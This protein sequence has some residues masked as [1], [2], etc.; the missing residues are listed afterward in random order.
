MNE[1][2]GIEL[3][4]ITKNFNEKLETIKN[5][6]VDF[7]KIA[8]QNF[9]T[10]LYMDV[11]KAKNDLEKLEKTL[12][13]LENDKLKPRNPFET[14]QELPKINNNIQK[15]KNNINILKKDISALNNS[16]ITKLGLLFSKLKDKALQFSLYIKNIKN[17]EKTPIGESLKP[18]LKNIKRF[19]L[20]LLGLH[21]IWRMV[22]RASSSYLSQDIELSNKLQ[23]AWIGL[24]ATIAPILEGMANLFVKMVSYF[25]IFIKSL[26]GVDYLSKA[27]SKATNKTNNTRKAIKDLKGELA[28]FDEI[29]NIDNSSNLNNGVSPNEIGWVNAFNDV[30][31]DDSWVKAI[32]DFGEWLKINAE[33]ISTGLFIITG[34]ILLFK[35]ALIVTSIAL[36]SFNK[37]AF[38]I[39]L[40]IIGLSMAIA[41]VTELFKEGGNETKAWIY[42]LG[43]LIA[44]VAG[45]G[46]IFGGIPAIIALV[47]GSVLAGILFITKHWEDILGFVSKTPNFI[48]DAF[49]FIGDIISTPFEEGINIIKGVWEGAKQFF[50]GIKEFFAGIFTLDTN[51]IAGGLKGMLRGMG[52]IIISFIEGSINAFLSPI[53]MA[54]K[55]IN[56][57][58]GISI[59]FLKVRVPKIPQLNVGTNYVKSDGLAMIH[60]GEAVVPKKFNSK[61][62][63][64]KNNDETNYL[65]R[66]LI[67]TLEEKDLNTYIDS[68]KMTSIIKRNIKNEERILGR[69]F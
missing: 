12:K 7:G 3:E 35:G 28:G 49:K 48:L 36:D 69:S 31:L 32:K 66:E 21:S 47:V 29:N 60:E 14:W 9:E 50:A 63:F 64:N 24:G 52:N 43:G 33:P 38:G 27:M 58:P 17:E 44:V 23:A 46:L 4:I 22:S 37:K 68:K 20:S 26:T 42:I 5:K 62:F 65:L 13:N 16:K 39:T 54:I 51:R 6:V 2:F 45:V 59:P 8:K 25:N 57:I 10:G 11:D 1:K 56:K 53:N 15:V 19:S 41:G 40:I 67:K 61:E 34:T 55:T 30:K 18:V